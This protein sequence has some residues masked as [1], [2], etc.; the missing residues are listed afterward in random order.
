[1]RNPFVS[2]N[3]IV[4]IRVPKTGSTSVNHAVNGH[5][6]GGPGWRE[7]AHPTHVLARDVDNWEELQHMTW[8]GGIRHP[9]TWIPSF[10]SW[11]DYIDNGHVRS[12]WWRGKTHTNWYD[13]VDGI[14][15]TPFD[16]L[17][18]HTISVI[19]C[20]LEKPEVIEDL[21]KIRL[22]HANET[23]KGD[24]KAFNPD[25][26]TMDLI[27]AKFHRELKYYGN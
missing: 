22:P 23:P 20:P 7:V 1:M 17:E 18:H 9:Y 11:L 26:R 5:K 14:R 3:D 12:R 15:F 13:F 16:W 19:P 27:E 24:R 8:I 10:Y 2:A 6:S 4:F 21:L 25:N